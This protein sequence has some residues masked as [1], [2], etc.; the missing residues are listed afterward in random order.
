MKIDSIITHIISLVTLFAVYHKYIFS[1]I[2]KRGENLK[3][4]LD[5]KLNREDWEHEKELFLKL[6]SDSNKNV[7]DSLR[8]IEKRITRIEDKLMN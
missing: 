4:E 2:E 7:I 6:Y 3:N 8:R 1:L 5:K